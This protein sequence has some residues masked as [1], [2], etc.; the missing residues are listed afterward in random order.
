MWPRRTLPT[1]VQITPSATT[2]TGAVIEA[3]EMLLASYMKGGD[4]PD[5]R[6]GAALA[7]LVAFNA[8]AAS[9][10]AQAVAHV[11]CE[12]TESAI[13]VGWMRHDC[14]EVA[15][16]TSSMSA[17]IEQLAMSTSDLSQTSRAC[18][19]SAESA[20]DIMRSCIDDSQNAT[21]A[22]QSIA[23]LVGAIGERMNV[24]ESAVNHIGGMAGDIDA[25]A[26]QTNLLALNATIEAARA[27]EAGRGFAV[28]ASEVKTLSVQ[29]GTATQ[30]IRVRL[31][32]LTSEVQ[33]IREAVLKSL[34]SVEKGGQTV[35]QVGLVIQGAGDEVLSISER[36]L[37]LSE[38]LNQQRAAT[39]EISSSA[40]KIAEKAAKIDTEVSLITDRLVTC[41]TS[42]LDVLDARSC[43]NEL[44]LL[45]IRVAPEACAWKRL[46][47]QRLLGFTSGDDISPPQ[48]DRLAVLARKF[49]DEQPQ[50]KGL[51]SDLLQSTQAAATKAS[52][53]NRAVMAKDWSLATPS[54]LSCEEQLTLLAGHCARLVDAILQRAAPDMN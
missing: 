14:R 54:Y 21:N 26:K 52:D 22:M 4:L 5:G 34:Q 19:S 11:G 32:T 28:V 46:L 2:E 29:T 50:V 13:N 42:A 45:A 30:E 3:V 27:G 44:M 9:R 12:V 7:K 48:T 40:I 10:S 25:I 41:E 16:S 43:D 47:A 1:P 53:M 17:A 35:Q 20:R 37:G 24:L 33:E 8:K 15:Q 31:A 38:L 49:S 6:L 36:I 51:V 39:N 18:A 23:G